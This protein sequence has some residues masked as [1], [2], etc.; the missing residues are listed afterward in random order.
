MI[1]YCN[2][3]LQQVFIEMTLK[4]EQEEY[5]REVSDAFPAPPLL[6]DFQA[7]ARSFFLLRHNFLAVVPRWEH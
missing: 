4:E 5:K 1:N 2:E 7:D 6:D 3:K